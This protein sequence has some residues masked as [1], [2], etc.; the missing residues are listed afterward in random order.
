MGVIGVMGV[1]TR[2]RGGLGMSKGGLG[3][4]NMRLER[5]R[6]GGG[7]MGVAGGCD[8]VVGSEEVEVEGACL[9]DRRW[10]M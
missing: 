6:V 3:V 1:S 7:P 2:A 4:R 10:E 8:D 9:R 5:W